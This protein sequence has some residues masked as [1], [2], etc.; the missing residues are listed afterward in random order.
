M[1]HNNR[2]PSKQ[3]PKIMVLGL[4]GTIVSLG[5][6]RSSEYY[7][8]DELDISTILKDIPEASRFADLH[9]D[10][11]SHKLSHHMGV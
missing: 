4:G 5:E 6:T 3:L 2:P 9:C 10:V 1:S 7:S 11:I 8:I